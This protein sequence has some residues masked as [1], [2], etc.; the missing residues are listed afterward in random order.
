MRQPT[1]DPYAWHRAALAGERPPIHM[2][3]VNC[4]WF[5][6]RLVRAGPFVPARIWL[7]RT[8][9]ETTGEL[10]SDEVLCCDVNGKPCD[11][12]DKWTWLAGHPIAESEYD[13][14]MKLAGF[15]KSYDRREPLAN[16]KEPTD[17]MHVPP[18]KFSGALRRNGNG[19]NRTGAD[20]KD[21]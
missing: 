17:L 16:P 8:L 15:A 7:E 19:K 20:R 2:D 10:L 5:K 21:R 12:Q 3:E 14:L 1:A 6:T 11:P 18:P 4:G 9:D 13:Y